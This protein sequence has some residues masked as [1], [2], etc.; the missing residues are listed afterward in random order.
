MFS[1]VNI[2]QERGFEMM[3]NDQ[4]F[5]SNIAA[6][7]QTRHQIYAKVHVDGCIAVIYTHSSDLY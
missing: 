3:S 7:E 4:A 6:F 2:C 5:I 1:E